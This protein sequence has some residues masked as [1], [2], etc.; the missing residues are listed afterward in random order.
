MASSQHS[1]QSAIEPGQGPDLRYHTNTGL[2][3]STWL[4]FT[5]WSLTCHQILPRF[6]GDCKLLLA[7]KLEGLA[8][9]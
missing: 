8:G 5:R 9:A 6:S 2:S 1:W 3:G 4:A 7:F